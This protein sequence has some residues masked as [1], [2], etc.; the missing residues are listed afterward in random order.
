[1]NFEAMVI[2]EQGCCF[3][4]TEFNS[5]NA[6][7]AIAAA[8]K[9]AA[10]RN[11]RYV[12]NVSERAEIAGH[13]WTNTLGEWVYKGSTRRAVTVCNLADPFD[14]KRNRAS[15]LWSVGKS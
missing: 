11:G 4:S 5:K 2:N 6:K 14:S 7:G 3:D 9:W 8:K 15:R 1:M 12:L 13:L 10:G